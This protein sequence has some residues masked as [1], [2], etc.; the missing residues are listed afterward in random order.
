MRKQRLG[1]TKIFANCHTHTP[2]SGRTEMASVLPAPELDLF[3]LFGALWN[4]TA[5]VVTIRKDNGWESAWKTPQRTKHAR[6]Y[7]DLLRALAR[8]L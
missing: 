3:P 8:A 2:V 1:E 7:E 6:D 5:A 4:I